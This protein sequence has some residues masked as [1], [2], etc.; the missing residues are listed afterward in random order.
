ML[1]NHILLFLILVSSAYS[2]Y[3]PANLILKDKATLQVNICHN[4]QCVV[5]THEKIKT[6]NYITTFEGKSYITYIVNVNKKDVNTIQEKLHKTFPKIIEKKK[7]FIIKKVPKPLVDSL[8]VEQSNKPAFVIKYK[9]ALD[10]FKKKNYEKSYILFTQ[11]FEEKPNDIN[12]NF[13]L[14]RSA[15]ET[16]RYH[17]ST[18]AYES[19]LFEKPNNTRVK[20][21]LARAFFMSNIIKESKR[22]FLEVKKDPKLPDLTLKIVNFYLKAIDQKK[23]K[24]FVNGII[25]AGVLYDSNIYSRS[26]HENFNNVYLPFAN[27]YLDLT[28]T[29]ENASNWYNQE[30]AL[31]NYKY[32]LSDDKVIKQDVMFYNKDSFDSTY[33]DT[34]VFLA[35]YAPAL[36]VKYN[37]KLTIDYALYTDYLKYAGKD[38]LKTFALFPKY[39]YRYNQSS[40][41]SGYIKYQKKMD[42]QDN[43]KDSTYTELSTTLA[44][45]YNNKVSITS[46]ILI[47][48]ESAKD[49][50]QTGID[51][52]NIKGTLSLNYKY[53]PTLYFTP[54]VSYS[55]TKYKDVDS[56]FLEKAENKL[57]KIAL[58]STYIYSPKWI[59]QSSFDKTTQ[60]SNFSTNE[61]DKYTFALNLIRT[62]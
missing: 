3:T 54:N 8:K 22:L 48:D 61:Y 1:N 18:I 47:A 36:S 56:S 40:N 60:K 33:D 50:S 14:G 38:K 17:E 23:N 53:I 11:L 32:K 37:E 29:T 51:Y 57:F 42:M 6:Y 21:E 15:Y 52:S 16:K 4:R 9:L 35:S 28:N 13:Y 43:T 55:V 39:N 59:V 19:F 27:V 7:I 12:I 45:N 24:H 25:M 2:K 41:L 20:L 62:F 30:V 5:K 46:N 34:K 26:N 58:S 31:I 10:H 44:H 49:S